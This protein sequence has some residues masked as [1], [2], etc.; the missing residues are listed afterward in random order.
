MSP[1]DRFFKINVFHEVVIVSIVEEFTKSY[2][3]H[4]STGAP[5]YETYIR[6]MYKGSKTTG[7]VRKEHFPIEFPYSVTEQLTI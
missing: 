4:H 1:G 2:W 3:F 5:I 7:V 6:Y